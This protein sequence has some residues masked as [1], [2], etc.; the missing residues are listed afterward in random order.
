VADQQTVR[1]EPEPRPTLALRAADRE[2]LGDGIDEHWNVILLEGDRASSLTEG[3]EVWAD[4]DL[5]APEAPEPLRSDADDLAAL[6][7]R[8]A[9]EAD[10]L[11]AWVET[12]EGFRPSRRLVLVDL[13]RSLVEVVA[14][15]GEPAHSR[16][17][18]RELLRPPRLGM[19]SFAGFDAAERA[20]GRVIVASVHPQGPAHA[21]GLTAG[22]VL[23]AVDGEELAGLADLEGQRRAW[24][25]G[26][27]VT[28]GVV[29]G[30]GERT[31]GL[32]V[33]GTIGVPRP[34]GMEQQAVLGRLAH[35]SV[36]MNLGEGIT[37][38]AGT[39]YSGLALAAL[40]KVQEAAT[41]L[42]R[43]SLD[44]T[45]DPAQDARATGWTVLEDQLRKLAEGTY[46]DEVA[47]RRAELG[48][49]R[50]GGRDGPPLRWAAAADAE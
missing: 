29:D 43:A 50:F 38:A 3:L 37:R 32:E 5:G 26:Q 4:P 6:G 12:R 27:E 39:L 33:D 44:E 14:W 18:A 2:A 25:P 19:T 21:A 45:T 31:V 48:A 20:D 28:L 1:L 7:R 8:L 46:A 11:A 10:L 35:A 47:A 36:A 9:S 16:R 34:G 23:A 30:D 41:A 24:S 49:A 17:A 13:G 42:D 22:A 15:T 40:D